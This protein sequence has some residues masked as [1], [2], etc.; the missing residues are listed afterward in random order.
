MKL[1]WLMFQTWFMSWLRLFA[2]QR[3]YLRDLHQARRN[4]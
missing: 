1:L 3:A 2:E 4:R